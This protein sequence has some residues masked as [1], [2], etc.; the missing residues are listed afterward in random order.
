MVDH[1]GT[2]L[3][4]APGRGRLAGRDAAGQADPERPLTQV[5]TVCV[6]WHATS[7]A[8]RSPPVEPGR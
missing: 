6:D 3:R 8:L 7:V 2:Q 4:Q 1:C 5:Q